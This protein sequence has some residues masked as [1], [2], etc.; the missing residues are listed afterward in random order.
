M[1]VNIVKCSC[2]SLE[3]SQHCW[4]VLRT[5][6]SQV[7]NHHAVKPSRQAPFSKGISDDECKLQYAIRINHRAS[8]FK[9]L[10]LVSIFKMKS[11]SL[12]PVLWIQTQCLFVIFCLPKLSLTASVF[13]SLII[14]TYLNPAS[15]NSP[16]QQPDHQYLSASYTAISNFFCFSLYILENTFGSPACSSEN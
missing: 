7:V 11:S 16:R 13:L 12:V 2:W 6:R 8:V 14:L 5:F 3:T 1:V 4:N 10:E 9:C 15:N